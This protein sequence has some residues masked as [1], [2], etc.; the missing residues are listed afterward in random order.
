VGQKTDSHKRGSLYQGAKRAR[1]SDQPRLWPL[2]LVLAG[3]LFAHLLN[4]HLQWGLIS[5]ELAEKP[6]FHS[7]EYTFI[8]FAPFHREEI[9]AARRLPNAAPTGRIFAYYDLLH[10]A[11]FMVWNNGGAEDFFDLG[12]VL[13]AL[14]AGASR[15]SLFPGAVFSLH[16]GKRQMARNHGSSILGGFWAGALNERDAKAGKGGLSG[17]FVVKPASGS[18]SQRLPY[19]VFFYLPLALI[20][21]LMA[22]TGTGMAT[23]FFYY[24]VAFFLFDFQKFFVTVPLAWLFAALKVEVPDPWGKALAVTMA[25]F[26]LAAAVFG[27]LRWK[28]REM[29]L[30]AKWIVLFFVL[31]PLALFF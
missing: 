2:L 29:P 8:G 4:V 5:G 15:I 19:L 20:A 27:L 12:P 24:A 9:V 10:P 22:T 26:F 16:H 21:I 17:S 11:V 3:L 6:A 7:P 14:P 30:G 31:L 18:S 13:A 1:F 28:S 23:A 25:L